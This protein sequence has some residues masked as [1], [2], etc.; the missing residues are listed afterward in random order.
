MTVTTLLARI[1]D[2]AVVPVTGGAAMLLLA[3][4][5]L[6]NVMEIVGRTA[7]SVS[8]G[9]IFEV[10]L[11][12]AAWVYFLGIVPVYARQ[13]DITVLGLKNLLPPRARRGFEGLVTVVSAGTFLLV[14]WHAVQLMRLQ[15][16]MRTPGT[17]FTNALYTMPLAIGCTG[18]VLV[19][20]R[21]LLAGTEERA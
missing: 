17:G 13:G 21:H 19:L 7:F 8:F 4:I 1:V 2:R 11:L 18:L 10:N 6:I 9:W 20:A 5:M 12:L 14:G 16:P 15:W 3:A